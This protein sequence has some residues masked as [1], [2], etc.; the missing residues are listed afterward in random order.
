ML[1]AVGAILTYILA[2]TPF[3]E[4][5]RRWATAEDGGLV[6]VVVECPSAWSTLVGG[7]R[8]DTN[9]R[10]EADRCV[11]AASTHATG[12]VVSPLSPALSRP[13]AS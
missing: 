2:F 3:D 12:A 9:L 13:A 10:T 8:L 4:P 7:E 1:V 5:M 11:R 6:Q